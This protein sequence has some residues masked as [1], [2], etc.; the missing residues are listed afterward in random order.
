MVARELE[1]AQQDELDQVAVVQ[2]RR[3]RVEAAVIGDR[4]VL[5]SRAQGLDISRLADQPAP[6]EFIKNVAH[7]CSFVLRDLGR[8]QQH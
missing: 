2:A 4:T 8:G 5:E 1:V 7:R 6:L 3:G